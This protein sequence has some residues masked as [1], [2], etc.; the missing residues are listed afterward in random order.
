MSDPDWLTSHDDKA[1]SRDT[2]GLS[3]GLLWLRFLV[4]FF[5]QAVIAA[6]RP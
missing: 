4:R 3:F 2:L 5:W 6:G 1:R